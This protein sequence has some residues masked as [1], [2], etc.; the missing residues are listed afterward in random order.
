MFIH[1][2]QEVQ[3][4]HCLPAALLMT[5]QVKALLHTQCG[6]SDRNSP[7]QVQMSEKRLHSNYSGFTETASVNWFRVLQVQSPAGAPWS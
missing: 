7:V 5:G 3:H 2:K 1:I 4:E 6:L